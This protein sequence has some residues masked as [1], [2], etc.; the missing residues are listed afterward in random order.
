MA[1]MQEPRRE[2]PWTCVVAVA[3]RR[4]MWRHRGPQDP[5]HGAAQQ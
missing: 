2:M 4:L 1:E 5:G 3:A